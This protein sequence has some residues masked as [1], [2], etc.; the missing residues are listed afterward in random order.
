MA[1]LDI[2][3]ELAVGLTPQQAAVARRAALADVLF[4]QGPRWAPPMEPEGQPRVGL[5]VLDGIIARHVVIA[6]IG[7]TELLGSGDLL[8][9]WDQEEGFPSIPLATDWDVVK[10]ARIALLD[11]GF[12]EVMAQWPPIA[13][14]LLSRSVRRSQS[15]AIHLA[16]TCLVGIELR[17]H[18]LFWHLADRWGR[19]EPGGV[20][21][22]LHLTHET[23]G[24]LV[25]SRRS[26]VTTALGKLSERATVVRRADGTWLLCGDPPVALTELRDVR[27]HQPPR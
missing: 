16:I 13:L 7:C 26:A 4:A 15:L 3:A 20:A 1:V 6:G 2:D 10:P 9:P 25:R 12:A 24:R 8:R 11:E 14:N 21:L 27:D 22:P 18:V 17:L 5:L 19:V 23:L